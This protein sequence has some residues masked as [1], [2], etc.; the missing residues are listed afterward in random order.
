MIILHILAILTNC[1]PRREERERERESTGKRLDSFKEILF[2][3]KDIK[4]ISKHIKISYS[5]SLI[6]H[7]V[8]TNK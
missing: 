5:S 3:Q 8:G 7:T 1:I 4:M 2:L 6:P